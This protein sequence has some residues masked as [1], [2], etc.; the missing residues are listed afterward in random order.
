MQLFYE[1]KPH[2]GFF[3][4]LPILLNSNVKIIAS[5][6]QSDIF[7]FELC[8]GN[9]KKQFK[10]NLHQAVSKFVYFLKMI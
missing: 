7:N 10:A 3:K 8:M 2:A 6:W 1:P 4:F 5:E 9:S